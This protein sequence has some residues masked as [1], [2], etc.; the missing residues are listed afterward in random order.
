MG[1]G[2]M[3]A[4]VEEFL[5][6]L[7]R[8]AGLD[9][10]FTVTEG[11]VTGEGGRRRLEVEISGPDAG[12]MVERN[13][14]LLHALE[15]MMVSLLRLQPEEQELVHFDA[16]GFK[17]ERLEAMQRLA[18]EAVARVRESGE[19]Y[20]FQ[21][22]NSLERRMLHLQLLESGLATASSGE[23]PRRFVVLYPAGMTP[24]PEQFAPAVPARRETGGGGRFGGRAGG[25]FG[26][27]PGGG[28]D[29]G[30]RTGGPWQRGGRPGQGRPRAAGG[31]PAEG[32][33]A[34]Q[35]SGVEEQQVERVV[36]PGERLQRLDPN[37][38]PIETR[39]MEET[40][41][42]TT[43]QERLESLRRAFRKR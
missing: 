38:N 7:Q 37:G 6:L 42:G 10:A 20:V 35:G 12:L 30:G 23:G 14:E 18:A 24:T 41:A 32:A 1:D 11:A 9:F 4:T 28:G 25:R 13:G 29:R 22:M 26:G 40:A 15:S 43:E 17:R 31:G 34:I 5:Q 27:R 36:L 21:P 19:P 8:T 2:T 39:E 33:E 3:I 16:L